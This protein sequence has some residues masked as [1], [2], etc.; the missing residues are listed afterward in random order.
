MSFRNTPPKRD[1]LAPRGIK[2][3]QVDLG[4]HVVYRAAPDYEAEEGVITAFNKYVVYVLYD[5]A[6]VRS[7][8]TAREDLDWL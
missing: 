6:S 3:E 4:R 5:G 7:Q 1:K 2:P 8:P